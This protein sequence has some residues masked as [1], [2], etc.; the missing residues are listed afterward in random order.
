MMAFLHS[1]PRQRIDDTQRQLSHG[2]GDRE[3]VEYVVPLAYEIKLI[4]AVRFL[5]NSS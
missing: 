1:K 4:D 5:S 3:R 2:L